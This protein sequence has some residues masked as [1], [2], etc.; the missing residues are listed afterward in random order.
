MANSTIYESFTLPSKGMIYSKPVDPD[1]T[2][3]SMTTMEEMARQSQSDTPY[4]QMSDIIED[5]LGKK[6]SIFFVHQSFA[7]AADKIQPIK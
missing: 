6:S 5:C 3:R 2:I 4:K 1:F 7:L